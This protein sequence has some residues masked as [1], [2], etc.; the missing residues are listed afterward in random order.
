MQRLIELRGISTVGITV[1]ADDTA[2]ANPPRAL[3][4]SGSRPGHSL[5]RAGDDALQKRILLD[6]LDL[7]VH[8][9]LPGDIVTKDYA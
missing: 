7:V 1:S 2:Q 6:A 5:G 3:C 9:V 8:P 4:P